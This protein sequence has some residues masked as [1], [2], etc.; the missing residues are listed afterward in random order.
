MGAAPSHWSRTTAAIG[1][2]ALL[3][4]ACDQ[5][6]APKPATRTFESAPCPSPNVEGIP[7]LDL[8]PEFSCGYLSVPENRSKPDRRTIKLAV[9]TAKATS[10]NPKPDPLVY[11]TGG[12][13]GPGLVPAQALVDA[14]I[15]RD[16]DVIFVDQRGTLHSDPKLTCPEIDE[17]MAKATA[18]S[19]QL[20]STADAD[21]AA[22]G[23]CHDRLAAAGYDLSAYNTTENAADLA[24]LRAALHIDEWNVYGV[25]Y[26]GDLALQLLRDH[27]EGIRSV[28][29]DSVLPPQ[30]NVMMQFWPSAAEGI[31]ALFDACSAQ[32]G[33]AA[34]YP[35]LAGDFTSAVGRLGQ[36]PL[37]VDL[38]ADNGKAP[39]RVVIDGYT[40]ANMVVQSSLAPGKFAALPRTIHS[41]ATGD[42]KAAATEIVNGLTPPGIIGYG[43][44]YGVFCRED[45]P[46]AEPAA[47]IA[48][49]A[50]VFPD[51]PQDVLALEPQAPRLFSDCSVWDVGRADDAVHRPARSDVP[52]LLMNGTLDAV[53]PRSQA[54]V[55]AA[56]LPHSLL[57]PFPG[58]GHDVYSASDCGR[59]VMADFLNRPDG[60]DTSCAKAIKPPTFLS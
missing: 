17:F 16:R 38:P 46:F 30:T 14:G 35:N 4:T 3:L 13:G 36:R 23:A 8:G 40:F 2:V 25:S 43:L 47:A 32:P 44:T 29:L 10:P 19:V 55:A 49:A 15:N 18:T 54:E 58:L 6:G 5:S 42:G 48:A 20:P 26:G 33:C 45:A 56:T 28:V 24:D 57:V 39:R 9:A 22:V 41:V 59:Q 37:V 53:A 27:P 50:Q 52:V 34:A 31:R 12:P 7:G 51:F 1:V 60:Y 21:I 11:L